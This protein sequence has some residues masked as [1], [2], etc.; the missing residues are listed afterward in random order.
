MRFEGQH[1]TRFA[2]SGPVYLEPLTVR[3]RPRSDSAQR[4][5]R[6]DVAVAPEPAGRSETT[7][8]EGNASLLV[9]FEGVTEAL[10]VRTSFA[11][12][13]LRTNPFDYVVSDP[14]A[15]SVPPHHSEETA[16]AL[17]HYLTWS[18]DED[19][20]AFAGEVLASSD[21][22]LQS[23]LDAMTS[24]VAS[25]FLQ[26]PRT[27]GDPRTPGATLAAQMG[28]C[29]DLTVLFMD[30]CR[31]LGIAARFVSG[32]QDPGD[33]TE[34]DLH[35]W[36]EVFVPGAGWRG[37]DPSA[38]L[39]VADRHVAVATGPTPREAA[40]TSGTFR[41]T[42]VKSTLQTKITLNVR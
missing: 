13:T 32:Y 35:A 37:Y 2:Y 18:G 25:S 29:R 4:L 36:A 41:G 7:D 12:E 22:R 1:L 31:S 17:S 11:V 20:R 28:A 19:V 24:R 5:L 16:A 14:A 40:P 27:Q 3:L 42:G 8:V 6:F 23:F 26:V 15:L 30:A 34:R 10:E 21:G 33:G 38:G 9:W 39:A